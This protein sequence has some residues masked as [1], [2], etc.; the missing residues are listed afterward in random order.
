MIVVCGE[1]LMDVF[2]AHTRQD[3]LESEWVAGGSA[4]NVARALCALGQPVSLLAGL[5]QDRFGLYLRDLLTRQ[6]V[7]LAY[8]VSSDKPTTLAIVQQDGAG[9][10]SFSFYGNGADVQV[11]VDDLPDAFPDSVTSLVMGSYALVTP[12]I[13]GALAALMA[14]D[15]ASR[16][17]SIDLNYRPSIVGPPDR[18]QAQFD[19]ALGHAH[20][21]KAS[22]E[23]LQLAYGP[24]AD[25]RAIAHDWRARGVALVLVTLGAQ[26]AVAFYQDQVLPVEGVRVT[27]KDT[28]GAGDAFHAAFLAWFGA[29][30]RLSL[31]AMPHWGA[32]D[33]SRAMAYAVSVSAQMCTVRG[34]G[35]DALAALDPL[36]YC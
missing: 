27:V 34:A 14:R 36:A 32:E 13:G 28:V 12:P 17:I 9:D 18:W 29:R 23:D 11:G 25:P 16:L 2:V 5:S 35:V 19:T 8:A 24:D 30:N 6:G 3:R 26:G 1:A 4:F 15:S 20:I 22:L 10:H 31:S 7:D 33:V 21:V